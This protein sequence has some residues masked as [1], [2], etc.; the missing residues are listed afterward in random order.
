MRTGGSFP[1]DK[2]AGAWRWPLTSFS[3]RSQECMEPYLH[4]TNTSSWRGV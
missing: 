1:G 2:A 3:C 4:S